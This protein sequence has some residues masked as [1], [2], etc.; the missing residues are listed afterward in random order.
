MASHVQYDQLLC[1]QQCMYVCMYVCMYKEGSDVRNAQLCT[2]IV[3]VL[4]C[5]YATN[6]NF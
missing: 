1:W 6:Y 5:Y 4:S 3:M 2:Y